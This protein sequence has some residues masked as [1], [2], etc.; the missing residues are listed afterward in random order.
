MRSLY[1]KFLTLIFVFLTTYIHSQITI[2]VTGNLN[3]T[4]N[5][6]ATYPDLATALNDL[7]PVSYTHLQHS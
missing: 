7:N 1:T 3:T 5:L 6:L 2:T 4:P